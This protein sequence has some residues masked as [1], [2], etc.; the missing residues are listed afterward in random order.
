MQCLAHLLEAHVRAYRLI[1][2]LY[3]EDS[4]PRP[5]VS[6]NNYASDLYW[7]DTAMIDLLFAP[8]RKMPRQLS[9]APISSERAHASS[10]PT[11]T[12]RSSSPCTARATS[13]AGG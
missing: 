7:S 11:S 1:H 2:E 13:S 10:T 6:F 5:R 12:P 8:S 9:C 3:A 4:G